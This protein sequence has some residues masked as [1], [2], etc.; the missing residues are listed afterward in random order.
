VISTLAWVTTRDARGHD[1]DEPPALAALARRGVA[2]EVVDW[3]DPAVD[4]AGFDRVVLRSAWDY[5]QRLA[6]FLTW[7]DRVAAVTDLVNPPATVRWSLDKRYLAELE[8]AGLPIT[9]TTF[10]EPGSTAS[11]PSGRFVVKPAVGAGSR[12]AASYD[13][14]QHDLALAHVARLHEMGSTVLVQPFLAS[15]A[16]DGEWP[17]VFVD[18][19]FSHAASKR[20]SLPRAGSVEDLFAAET[21]APHVATDEQV[22]VAQAVMDLVSARLGTPTYGRVDLVRDDAGR[23][24]V[25]ELELAEPSLFL[26]YA[27]DAAVET[28]VDALA[29]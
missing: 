29:R 14:D 24:C 20:V 2:T 7:V 25:L 23:S 13:D 4:W 12:D 17:M 6:E 5:P 19:R 26:R 9:P 1:E 11:L 28:L 27:D 3:D 16:T 18:G 10:V 15:V 22:Q 21:N 8:R